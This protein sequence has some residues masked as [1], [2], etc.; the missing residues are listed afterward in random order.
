MSSHRRQAE[1]RSS[2]SILSEDL[3][4]KVVQKHKGLEQL[5]S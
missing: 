2:S 4:Y 1:V 3:E 5:S